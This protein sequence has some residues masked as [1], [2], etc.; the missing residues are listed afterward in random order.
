MRE[1]RN[2]K[3][4]EGRRIQEKKKKLE[5]KSLLE[6]KEPEEECFQGQNERK[7]KCVFSGGFSTSLGNHHSV[8]R[9]FIR[10]LVDV[11]R[12]RRFQLC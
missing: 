2:E 4:R 5:G 6:K 1:F 10:P 9:S 11:V 12:R 7:V 3:R 8:I